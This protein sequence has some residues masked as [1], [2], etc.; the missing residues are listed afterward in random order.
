[1][2]ELLSR[3]LPF[4][5]D[6]SSDAHWAA[7]IASD[8]ARKAP[9]IRDC[10]AE[11]Q[12]QSTDINVAKVIAKALEK[13]RTCRQVLRLGGPSL[14]NGCHNLGLQDDCLCVYEDAVETKNLTNEH[15]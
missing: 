1:M 11:A 7:S 14:R 5:A 12:H 4:L 15:C 6:G 3:R 9:N 13:N 2:F 10:L 8:M